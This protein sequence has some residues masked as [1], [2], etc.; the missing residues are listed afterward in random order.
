MQMHEIFVDSKPKFYPQVSNKWVGLN[1][2]VGWKINPTRSIGEYLGRNFQFITWKLASTVDFF[3]WKNRPACLFIRDLRV[4]LTRSAEARCCLVWEQ[5]S[6]L[7][8]GTETKVQFWYRFRN[9]FFFPKPKLFFF[10]FISY[11]PTSF[12]PIKI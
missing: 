6:V 2:Q 1:K 7:V 4:Y 11:F 3:L 5:N 9:R 10:K 12:E 8:S